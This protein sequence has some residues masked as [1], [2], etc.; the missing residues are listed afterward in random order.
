MFLP[1]FREIA[2]IGKVVCRK[3]TSFQEPKSRCDVG[4]PFF[5][6]LSSDYLNSTVAPASVS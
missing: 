2:V 5:V 1:V 6:Q 3:T 4:F